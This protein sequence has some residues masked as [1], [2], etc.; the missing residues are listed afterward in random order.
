MTA[1]A[2][3]PS[4]RSAHCSAVFLKI[5]FGLILANASLLGFMFGGSY[6]I[7]RFF[8]CPLMVAVILIF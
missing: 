8:P 7:S 6:M 4:K 3:K 5:E 2:G 1:P